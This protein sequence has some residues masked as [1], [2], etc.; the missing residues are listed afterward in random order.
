MG[1]T[2]AAIAMLGFFLGVAIV[3]WRLTVK[4]QRL[5]D[6]ATRVNQDNRRLVRESRKLNDRYA[7]IKTEDEQVRADVLEAIE[8]HRRAGDVLKKMKD[9]WVTAD[10]DEKDAIREEYDRVREDAIDFNA[11]LMVREIEEFKDEGTAS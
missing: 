7:E 9:G 3:D 2:A 10:T 8:I 4:W 6:E 11:R 5:K 1:T